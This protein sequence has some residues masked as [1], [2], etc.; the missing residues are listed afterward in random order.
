MTIKHTP[1]LSL[2][3]PIVLLFFGAVSVGKHC[4]HDP[5]CDAEKETV[6]KPSFFRMTFY[7]HYPVHFIRDD[8]RTNYHDHQ[9][10]EEQSFGTFQKLYDVFKVDPHYVTYLLAAIVSA[11]YCI[12]MSH[13]CGVKIV[14]LLNNYFF[15]QPKSFTY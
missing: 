5:S 12:K 15:N 6:P 13:L 7:R 1:S 11:V 4:H 2:F 9:N 3:Y 8:S 10:A 14:C